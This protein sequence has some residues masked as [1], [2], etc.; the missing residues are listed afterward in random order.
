MAVTVVKAYRPNIVGHRRQ[1]L[2]SLTVGVNGDTFTVPGVHTVQWVSSNQPSALTT[3][4]ASGN[5]LTFTGTA[6][7]AMVE[8]IGM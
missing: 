5:V 6:T 2:Y 1:Y 3:I 8:V 4:A 7:A